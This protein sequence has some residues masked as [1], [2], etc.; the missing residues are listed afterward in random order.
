MI[1]ISLNYIQEKLEKCD[2][3]KNGVYLLKSEVSPK[4]KLFLRCLGKDRRGRIMCDIFRLRPELESVRYG[5]KS[6]RDA[7]T[8]TQFYEKFRKYTFTCVGFLSNNEWEDFIESAY[9]NYL[10]QKLR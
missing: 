4:E 9:Y 3:R 2:L 7:I 8:K 5:Q 6:C 10:Y 1:R